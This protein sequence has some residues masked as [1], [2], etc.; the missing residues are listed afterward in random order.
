MEGMMAAFLGEQKPTDAA[1]LAQRVI[2]ERKATLEDAVAL[3]RAVLGLQQA[4]KRLREA[5]R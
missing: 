5:T 2:A 1:K 3:A 4:L